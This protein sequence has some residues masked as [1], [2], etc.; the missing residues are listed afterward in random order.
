M[1]GG[2]T[3]KELDMKYTL[4]QKENTKAI[5]ADSIR[6]AKRMADEAIRNIDD[7]GSCNFDETL[8]KVE[9]IFSTDETIEIF[10][11]CGVTASQYKKGWLLVGGSHGQAWK[12]TA[13]HKKFA[14]ILAEECFTTSIYYQLD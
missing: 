12:N 6:Y 7:N 4:F 14:E 1:S 2:N 9:K 3:D 10:K 8:V 13:W 11:E 5:W